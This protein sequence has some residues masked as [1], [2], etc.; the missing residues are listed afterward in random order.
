MRI[1]SAKQKAE[2]IWTR[3][4]FRSTDQRVALHPGD[5]QLL[6]ES[7]TDI[8]DGIMKHQVWK[9]MTDDGGS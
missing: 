5:R 2:D 8:R 7:Q 3:V 4:F 6:R 9:A 1:A